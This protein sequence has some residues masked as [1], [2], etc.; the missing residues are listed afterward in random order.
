MRLYKL[1]MFHSLFQILSALFES[2]RM[3]SFGTTLYLASLLGPIPLT[4][5]T[6]SQPRSSVI[7]YYISGGP[8]EGG[9]TGIWAGFVIWD[10]PRHP[11]FSRLES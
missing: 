7:T 1:Y 10:H 5:Y 3:N 6:G 8:R 4:L 2:R 9:V 11:P